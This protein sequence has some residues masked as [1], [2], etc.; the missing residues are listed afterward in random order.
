[1]NLGSRTR[2]RGLLARAVVA[3]SLLPLFLLASCGSAVDEPPNVRGELGVGTFY[4]TCSPSA[5]VCPK[6]DKGQGRPS[7]SIARHGRVRIRFERTNSSVTGDT[8]RAVSPSMLAESVDATGLRTFEALEAGSTTIAAMSSADELID[9]AI[10]G[11]ANPARMD[12]TGPDGGYERNV[13]KI[14]LRKGSTTRVSAVLFD[15]YDVTLAGD[16]SFSFAIDAPAVAPIDP[17]PPADAGAPSDASPP[18]DAAPPSDASSPTDAAA[19]PDAALPTA[20]TPTVVVTSTVIDARTVE[21]EAVE[22]GTAKLVV[23]G[24]GLQ[25]IVELEVT[26]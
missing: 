17:S 4:F 11:I 5:V 14:S 1:M 15:A 13:R 21:I 23:D 19:P 6:A 12:F 16:V 2:V 24:A 7:V 10:V 22:I 9:F 26:P 18:T 3:S 8:V 25:R 20:A